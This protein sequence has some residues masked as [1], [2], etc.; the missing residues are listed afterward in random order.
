[1]STFTK[2]ELISANPDL[3]LKMSMTKDAML[4]AI[5][6]AKKPVKTSTRRQSG[7]R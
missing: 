6:A 5:K 2:A 7:E 3:G 1:M 4:T